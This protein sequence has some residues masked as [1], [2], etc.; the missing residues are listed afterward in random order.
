MVKM[1]FRNCILHIVSYLPSLELQYKWMLTATPLVNSIE[2]L[3]WIL[4]F[5]ESISWLTL[6]LPPDTLDYTLNLDDHWVANGC[7]VSDTE[8]LAVF[9]TVADL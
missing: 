5:L 3:H 7:N 1:D 4:C 9:M 6:Q 2:D 8:H